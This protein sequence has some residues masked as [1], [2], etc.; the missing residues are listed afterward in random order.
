MATASSPSWQ[1]VAARKQK[2][3]YDAIPSA[4]LV[5]RHLLNGH[6]F[7]DLPMKCPHI[8]SNEEL[9]ITEQRA[10]DILAQ[11]HSRAWTSYQ[12][13]LAFCKR[14][15][16]AH[17]ATNCL[18]LIMFDSALERAKEL[19]AYM[20]KHNRPVGPLHGLPI[21]VK[22]HIYLENTP[23]TSGLISWADAPS[24]G[25]ALICKVFREAGAVF[26]VKTTN[27]Q[28][29]MA[30][31]THSNLFGRTLNPFNI[32]LTSGG[33]SG[34]ESALVAMR[35]S[36]LGIGTDIGGSIRG[37]SGFCGGWGLKASV[38]RIPHS[39]LSGL[40]SGMENIIGC[41]GPMANSLADLQLFCKVALAAEPWDFEPSLIDIPWRDV[42]TE[43]LPER[44]TIG[45][46]WE[47]NT[48]TP[49][50]PIQRALKETVAKL[51]AAGHRIVNWDP[52]H[53]AALLKWINAAY[54]LDGAAEY[55]NT[56]LQGSDPPVPMIE[57]LIDTESKP[58]RHTVEETWKSNSERD[59]LRTAFSV[60]WR[61]SGIDALLCPVNPACASAHDE[62]RYWGYTAVFNATDLPGVVFPVTKV[63][64][65]DTWDESTGD[66]KGERDELYRRYWNEGGWEK[67]KDAPVNL[68]LVGKRLR[69]E[70]L[71]A[72][73]EVVE[74]VIRAGNVTDRTEKTEEYVKETEMVQSRL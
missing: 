5:R 38:A 50:P 53:H 31:E 72:V 3:V 42:K 7:T 35:G 70:K 15:A 67:Y 19:D 30:L 9:F 37:P 22:E 26:H 47:D 66:V 52:Q 61:E 46:L 33:S 57:W 39:G 40:H 71:L 29:L 18:A 49:H 8:M 21:S 64:E 74:G 58:L 12:V 11:I 43:D 23:S 4:W 62:S 24:P 14:A 60:Q 48:V 2:E 44:L 65:T 54:F 45:V 25:D 59:R 13:T 1:D 34:G 36:P 51:R 27:P 28:T 10:V 56:L 32:N 17:Q 68:Q 69:E 16:L 41:V 6:N 73:A 63:L 55:K 20:A